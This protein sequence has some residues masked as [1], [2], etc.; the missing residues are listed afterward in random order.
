MNN[1]D[2]IGGLITFYL[3]LLVFALVTI[4]YSF[5]VIFTMLL[6]GGRQKFHKFTKAWAISA[7]KIFGIKVKKSGIYNNPDNNTYIYVAN[8]STWWDIP[9][10][11]ASIDQNVR[12]I[13]KKELEKIPIFGWGL[14]ACPYIS[15]DRSDARKSMQS[16]KEAIKSIDEGDSVI[17]YPEGTRSKTGKL[18][19]FKR[20][21]FMLA[22]KASKKII[23]LTLA[24]M[25]KIQPEGSKV[26]RPVE[27]EL[28]FHPAMDNIS[29]NRKEE[30][31]FRD[32]VRTI[33]ASGLSAEL[34]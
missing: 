16:L 5:C 33:V 27:I 7:L 20:G 15:I 34:R 18:G 6:P 3:K 24:G 9:V 26:I 28:R 32:K 8:H 22:S 1:A 19:E 31:E 14:A 11:I 30:D 4:Y 21:A 12:I 17:I 10:L 2:S 29:G 23:P 25:Q 13:Y